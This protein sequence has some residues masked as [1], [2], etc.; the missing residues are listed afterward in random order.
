MLRNKTLTGSDSRITS[1]MVVVFGLII[2]LVVTSCNSGGGSGVAGP[3]ASAPGSVTIM[4]QRD[5]DGDGQID[6][7]EPDD[8]N[9]RTPDSADLDDDND[10]IYDY[11][12]EDSDHDGTINDHDDDYVEIEGTVESVNGSGFV[13]Y[14]YDVTVDD[15]TAKVLDVRLGE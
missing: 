12:E 11:D 8:D 10:G 6:L 13:I 15:D 4:S 3:S 9:D 2:G 5:T 1:Y 14:G 7:V